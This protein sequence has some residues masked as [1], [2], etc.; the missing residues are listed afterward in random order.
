MINLNQPKQKSENKKD[1]SKVV[2]FK[3]DHGK[4]VKK[5]TTKYLKN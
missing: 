1:T 4:Q 3:K 5:K 2:E